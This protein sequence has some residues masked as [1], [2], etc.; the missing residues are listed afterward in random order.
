MHVQKHESVFS[1]KLSNR[2]L[3]QWCSG[4]ILYVKWIEFIRR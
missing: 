3:A 2:L 4:P 1:R